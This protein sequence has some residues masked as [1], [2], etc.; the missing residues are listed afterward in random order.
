MHIR[1]R[2]QVFRQSGPYD[3]KSFQEADAGMAYA[4]VDYNEKRPHS[5]LGYKSPHEFLSRIRQEKVVVNYR[6]NGRKDHIFK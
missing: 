4:F 1:H 2:D 6:K 3:F 5:S